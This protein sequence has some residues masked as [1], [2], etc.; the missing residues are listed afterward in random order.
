MASL[1]LS[2][3]QTQYIRGFQYLPRRK[4][5]LNEVALIVFKAPVRSQ[6]PPGVTFWSLSLLTKEKGAQR[7]QWGKPRRWE[8]VPWDKIV[9]GT[10]KMCQPVG[11]RITKSRTL[12]LQEVMWCPV[13]ILHSSVGRRR[14]QWWKYKIWNQTIGFAFK[15]CH[16]VESEH[17]SLGLS[18]P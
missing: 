13:W 15:F 11:G 2:L 8:L 4:V 14:K 17:T 5:Q 3:T 6:E 1:F 12:G 7:S 16:I 18:P 9:S 10:G